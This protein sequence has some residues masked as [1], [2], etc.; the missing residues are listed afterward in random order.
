MFIETQLGKIT[1]IDIA[2][3]DG[4]YGLY[5]QFGGDGWGVGKY[6]PAELPMLL[7]LRLL[8][9]DAKKTDLKDMVGTPAEVTFGDGAIISYRI[10]NEVI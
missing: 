2:D 5:I 4:R 7:A 3:R 10:L 8:L 6:L 1:A 9:K